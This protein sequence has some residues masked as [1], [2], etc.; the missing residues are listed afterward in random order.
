MRLTLDIN[1]TR[2]GALVV[3]HTFIARPLRYLAR[4]PSGQTFLLVSIALVVLVGMAAL[5]VDVG[6]LW[7]TRR[8]MQ[9][10]A[11]AGAMAGADELALGGSS[12]SITTV[13]KDATSHNGFTDGASRPGGSGNITVSVHNP[14]ISGA[15]AGNA[16]VVEVDV[17][18]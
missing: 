9:S 6:D 10:A 18:Q 16:N 7:T 4:R 17:S 12:S 15:Y 13:A 14:P 1:S 3:R 11:D 8:L 2:R 5:A